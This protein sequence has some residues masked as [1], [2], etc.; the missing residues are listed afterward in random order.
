MPETSRLEAGS[1][2]DAGGLFAGRSSG[3]DS[4]G[5]S[6]AQ[7]GRAIGSAIRPAEH[8]GPDGD[9]LNAATWIVTARAPARL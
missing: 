7:G 5:K 3:Q 4:S 2:C 8:D 1:R 6:R 9:R